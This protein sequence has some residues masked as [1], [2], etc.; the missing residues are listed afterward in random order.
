MIPR[1]IEIAFGIVRD[2][3]LGPLLVVG[4]G[5]I[6][7]ELI[8]DRAVA[9]PPLSEEQAAG[10]LAELKVGKL[11]AGAR[12]AVPANLGA[13]ARALTGLAGPA[14]ELAQDLEPLDLNPLICS[15]GRAI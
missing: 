10:L 11:L 8:A 14:T 3:D 4:A 13:I 15:P 12:G 6:L 5:G 7:V 2:P 1:G 9:L